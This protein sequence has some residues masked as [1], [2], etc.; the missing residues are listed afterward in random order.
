MKQYKTIDIAKYILSVGILI[1]HTGMLWNLKYGFYYINLVLRIAVPFFFVVAGYFFNKNTKKYGI[2]NSLK[3]YISRLILPYIFFST[4]YILLEYFA[5]H[6]S[7]QYIFQEFLKMISGNPINIM[8]FSGS[9]IWSLIIIAKLKDKKKIKY[10]L[11]I[12][13]LLYIIGLLFNT[14]EFILQNYN[15]ELL[16]ALKEVFRSNR[17]FWFVGYLYTAIGYLIGEYEFKNYKHYKNYL[18]VII[19]FLLLV[20]E[21]KYIKTKFDLGLIIEF[22]Y[23]LS[24]LIFIPSLVILLLNSRLDKYIDADTTILRGMSTTIY[25]IHFVFLYLFVII[26]QRYNLLVLLSFKN[27]VI[28]LLTAI[29]AFIINNYGNKK[30]K[31]LLS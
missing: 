15:N 22:D 4:L 19:S 6:Q 30:L 25:N 10:S 20:L 18:V 26:E 5:Q 24:H 31:R 12:A 21:V 14:Y 13:L 2:N 29:F 11:I 1:L 16:V 7:I 8:W 3:K 17:C 27:Y 23:Y 9:L 28:I